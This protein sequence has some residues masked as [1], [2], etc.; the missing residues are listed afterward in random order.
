MREF[1]FENVSPVIDALESIEN[2]PVFFG[3]QL[4]PYAPTREKMP[5][6]V[7]RHRFG[8]VRSRHGSRL[9]TSGF[10]E[11][12]R[13]VPLYGQQSSRLISRSNTV[14]SASGSRVFC[15][16]DFFFFHEI[17]ANSESLRVYRRRYYV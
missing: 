13:P 10:L 12:I 11:K 15:R 5:R 2:V 8:H 16:G 6:R 14:V 9:E 7:T 1:R 4:T 17:L 3:G